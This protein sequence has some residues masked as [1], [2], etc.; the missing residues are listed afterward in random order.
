MWNMLQILLI[1]WWLQLFGAKRLPTRS[2]ATCPLIRLLKSYS[3]K[4][5]NCEIYHQEVLIWFLAGLVGLGRS[6]SSWSSVRVWETTQLY[7][8]I[9]SFRVSLYL[10]ILNSGVLHFFLFIQCLEVQKSV[11][12][13][14][15]ISVL[16]Q[17][18]SISLVLSHRR[19]FFCACW[20][21][22]SDVMTLLLH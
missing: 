15:S 16:F 10:A 2:F 17:I 21:A 8:G 11:I 9:L 22:S 3:D 20:F 6:C 14:I 1:R 4:C 5:E 12:H 13:L 7:F 19:I 18:S